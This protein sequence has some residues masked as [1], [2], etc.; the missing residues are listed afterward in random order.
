MVRLRLT[1][2]GTDTNAITSEIDE[3]FPPLQNTQPQDVNGNFTKTSRL[4][5]LLANSFKAYGKVCGLLS[6]KVAQAVTFPHL[7]TSIPGSSA[8]YVGSVVSYDNAI[9]ERVLRAPDTL[10]VPVP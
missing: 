6:L 5:R 1:A 9:K 2:T 4:N 3:L 7:I 10:T 8:Y